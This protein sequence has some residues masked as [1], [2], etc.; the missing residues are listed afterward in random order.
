MVAKI[1]CLWQHFFVVDQLADN[2]HALRMPS[3]DCSSFSKT[4][5]DYLWW[6]GV[7]ISIGVKVDYCQANLIIFVL[8]TN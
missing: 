8:I 7:N 5:H 3:T 4:I 1:R 6:F 2:D